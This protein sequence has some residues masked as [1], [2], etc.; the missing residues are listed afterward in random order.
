[1]QQEVSNSN[2]LIALMNRFGSDPRALAIKEKTKRM[3]FDEAKK[4]GFFLIDNDPDEYVRYIGV[5]GHAVRA[6]LAEDADVKR[7]IDELSARIKSL[8][9]KYE[10]LNSNEI[11]I[12]TRER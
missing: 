11:P 2:Q 1:M 6:Y 7:R 12:V 9:D 3:R 8:L 5:N 4:G 10:V